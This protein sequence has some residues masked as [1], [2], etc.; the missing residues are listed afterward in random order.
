MAKK[1]RKS[2][3][4]SD[5]VHRQVPAQVSKSGKRDNGQVSNSNGFKKRVTRSSAKVPE[6]TPAA[7]DKSDSS[8]SDPFQTLA[9]RK[10]SG[11]QSTARSTVNKARGDPATDYRDSGESPNEDASDGPAASKRART[12][13]AHAKT[14]LKSVKDGRGRR[15]YHDNVAAPSDDEG[16]TSARTLGRRPDIKIKAANRA[17]R[18]RAVSSSSDQGDGSHEENADSGEKLRDLARRLKIAE[19]L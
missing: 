1:S 2:D 3:A 14:A 6:A 4:S 19:G 11:A 17:G 5:K 16:P 12:G 8:K 15:L 18:E 7:D 9:A 10:K 13:V